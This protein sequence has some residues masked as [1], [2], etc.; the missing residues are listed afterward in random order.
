MV[1]LLN[2]FWIAFVIGFLFM[3]FMPMDDNTPF[4]VFASEEELDE[5]CWSGLRNPKE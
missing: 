3:W 4:I 2:L 5:M 1:G